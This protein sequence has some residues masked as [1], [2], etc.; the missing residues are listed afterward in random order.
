MIPITVLPQQLTEPERRMKGFLRLMENA[1]K[2]AST[3]PDVKL[4]E[5]Y[6]GRKLRFKY[7]EDRSYHFIWIL[8]IVFA[9]LLVLRDKENSRTDLEKRYKQMQLDY[10]E[11]VS[12]LLLFVGAG[13]SVR[14]A[15]NAIAVDYEKD[16][17]DREKAEVRY[18]YEEL[19]RANTRLQTGAPE[20]L[21][22]R[23]YGRECH[24]KQYM[25]LA[26]LLEQNRRSGLSN[27][28]NLLQLEMVEAWEERK[29]A[30]SYGTVRQDQ[31]RAAP[32]KRKTSSDVRKTSKIRFCI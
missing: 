28:K 4:P 23:E 27:M 31:H 14:M 11:I 18:A 2:D 20:G 13:M 32:H 25:K 9:V 17:K 7:S 3:A 21:V 1:D 12:K 5:E 22:Y 19:C 6:E 10:S 30:R 26:S 24:S 15:W 16:M 29:T 8:G